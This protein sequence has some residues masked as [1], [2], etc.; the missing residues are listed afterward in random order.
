MNANGGRC[1]DDR[2]AVIPTASDK[3]ATSIQH[4]NASV[5][6][7]TIC[8]LSL[9]SAQLITPEFLPTGTSLK[10]L[11]QYETGATAVRAVGCSKE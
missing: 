2:F 9:S 11:V 10:L 5:M 1:D 4:A 7:V 6:K 3:L 8:N